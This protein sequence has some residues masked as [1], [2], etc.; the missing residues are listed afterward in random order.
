MNVVVLTTDFTP[1]NE[2]LSLRAHARQQLPLPSSLTPP[3]KITFVFL[4]LPF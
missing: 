2:Q 3:Q 1:P 4:P